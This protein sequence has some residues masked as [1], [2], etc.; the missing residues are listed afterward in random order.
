MTSPSPDLFG[1]SPRQSDLFANEPVRNNGIGVA[2]P[3][4]VRKRALTILAEARSAASKSPW[5]ERTTG[6]YQIIFPQMVNWLPI[7]EAA[8]LKLDFSSELAR[9]NIKAVERK[10]L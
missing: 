2:D 1:Y 6:L 8:Q 3:A 7:E 9:L 5:D 4:Q 10:S